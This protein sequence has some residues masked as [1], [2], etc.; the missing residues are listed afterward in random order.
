MDAGLLR[1]LVCG[2]FDNFLVCQNGEHAW[3]R[4]RSL[5]VYCSLK[6][7]I[8]SACTGKRNPFDLPFLCN[9]RVGVDY[10]EVSS[11]TTLRT[12]SLSEAFSDVD[13]I[14]DLVFLSA[15]TSVCQ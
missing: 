9:S 14:I 7:E 8:Y 1:E 13:D 5:L 6:S 15:L 4:N 10:D 12:V 3:E 2:H 11:D